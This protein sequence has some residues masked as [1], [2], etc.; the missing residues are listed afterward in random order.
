MPRLAEGAAIVFISSVAGLQ[1]GSRIPVQRRLEGGPA[2]PVSPRRPGGRAPGRARQRRRCPGS[3]HTPLGRLATRGRPGRART[4]V[5][6]G[7]QGSEVGGRVGD[8]VPPVGRRE[9][10]HRAG[11]R[12]RRR[13]HAAL[14]Q[15]GRG[16]QRLDALERVGHRQ[17][18]ALAGRA[19]D[20]LHLLLEMSQDSRTRVPPSVGSR[21]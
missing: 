15:A 5:P 3:I 8:R 1:P 11:A 18:G 6:L 14:N 17:P 13:P 21:S 19:H 7:R 2:R 4:P 16:D 12:R 9:L 10:R 20:G